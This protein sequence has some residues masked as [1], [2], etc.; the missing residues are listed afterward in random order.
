M[1]ENAFM[2]WSGGKDSALCLYKALQSKQYHIQGL[3]TNINASHHRVSM[4]GVRRSLLE[5]QAASIDIPLQTIELPEEP[6]MEEY[7]NIMTKKLHQ[8]KSSGFTKAIFGDIFLE[9]LKNYREQKL[10]EAGIE[11]AFPLW[12]I[13]TTELIKEFIALGFKAIIVCV[14]EN[15]LDKSFCGRLIDESF[16][17]DL[18][19][20]VDVC[21]ENGE[22]HSFVFE[23]PIFKQP[24][25][26]Y[27]GDIVYKKYEA[28]KT[29]DDNNQSNNSI[30]EY[31]FYFCD[32]LPA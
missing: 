31:G 28:P 7:E 22:F 16:I 8:L 4:H 1:N 32:L 19:Q 6:T 15:Y 13:D 17:N 11:C 20:N 27:K 5:A 3:L 21:G 24:T 26:F 14:N 23:G 18:P 9:D 29:M 10:K 30:A 2:N 12:K 25:K